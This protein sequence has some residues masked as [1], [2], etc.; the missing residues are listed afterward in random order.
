MIRDGNGVGGCSGGDVD[1]GSGSGLVIVGI[2]VRDK[3]IL[4]FLCRV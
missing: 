2:L 4:F 3:N 1:G